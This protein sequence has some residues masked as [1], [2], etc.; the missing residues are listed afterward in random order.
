MRLPE[1]E[2]RGIAA[3]QGRQ[4]VV[5]N[6]NDLLTGRDA[7]QNG[8][9]ERF[10]SDARDEFF[11]HVKI[12]VGFKQREPNLPQ[13]GVDVRL[14]DFAVAAEIFEDLLQLLA[15]LRKQNYFFGVT[16][17]AAAGAPPSSIPNV[18]CVSTFL[19]PDFALRIT[20]QL[21]SRNF[22]VT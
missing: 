13:R 2:G 21:L 17:G 6:V 7:A 5:K 3:E 10:V 16:A 4:F 15:E 19:S 8:F 9:V 20:V 22:C 11:R 1:I 14:T 18:Q 12:D